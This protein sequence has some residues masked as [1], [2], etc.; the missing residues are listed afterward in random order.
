MPFDQN[1]LAN[2][3]SLA[4]RRWCR[5]QLY[6]MPQPTQEK[7]VRA[8]RTLIVKPTVGPA[9]RNAM[10]VDLPGVG[11]DY[12]E[13]WAMQTAIS[14][15]PYLLIFRFYT[16]KPS[17][18][19]PARLF[20][21]GHSHM[22][23][24]RI[25]RAKEQG[26][27]ALHG[28]AFKPRELARDAKGRPTPP[29]RLPS[30]SYR[31]THTMLEKNLALHAS[32]ITRSVGRNERDMMV[33]STISGLRG[34]T[35]EEKAE[36][37]MSYMHQ[38]GRRDMSPFLSCTAVMPRMVRSGSRVLRMNVMPLAPYLGL[39]LVPAA[40]FVVQWIH[41]NSTEL[42]AVVYSVHEV[43]V[44]FR[45]LPP[46]ET[47]QLLRFRNP[48]CTKNAGTPIP[49]VESA[50]DPGT[51]SLRGTKDPG[52]RHGAVPNPTYADTVNLLA[53]D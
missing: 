13:S 21:T 48:F 24:I 4:F 9:I 14:Q 11:L 32:D 19:A 30:S 44:L 20:Q 27:G 26:D 46:M 40:N 10:S 33:F 15:S 6:D 34:K 2:T 51:T 49:G 23:M 17:E 47:F 16:G 12:Q 53:I 36:L 38:T 31:T 50:G 42:A 28:K 1:L 29:G 39:F 25:V 3:D 7:V 45:P 22:E 8:L 5:F 41:R 35:P 18:L 52:F 37:W 43:E